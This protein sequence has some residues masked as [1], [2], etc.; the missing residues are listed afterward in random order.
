MECEYCN[1]TVHHE[2]DMVTD[3]HDMCYHVWCDESIQEEEAG[4]HY[5]Q[6]S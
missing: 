4:V 1:E 5:T 2:F 6:I 3:E